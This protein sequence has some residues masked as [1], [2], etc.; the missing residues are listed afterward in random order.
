MNELN[1][2]RIAYANYGKAENVRRHVKVAGKTEKQFYVH[3]CIPMNK[4]Y[5]IS[6]L[7]I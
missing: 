3:N 5:K 7:K 6:I 2:Q 1:E 4:P